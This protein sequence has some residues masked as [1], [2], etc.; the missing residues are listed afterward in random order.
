MRAGQRNSRVQIF[1]PTETEGTLS[2]R[3]P[4]TWESVNYEWGG[5]LPAF[6]TLRNYGAGEAPSGAREIE[7]APYS[8]VQD[9]YGIEVVDGPESGTRWRAISIDRGNP[10]ITAVRLER[11]A[12]SFT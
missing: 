10:K 7:F 4:P 12:G 1:R 3:T 9:R 5:F 11:Y 8:S 6:M 2:S